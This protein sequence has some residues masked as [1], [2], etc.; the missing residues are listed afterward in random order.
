MSSPDLRIFFRTKSLQFPLHV[1]PDLRPWPIGWNQD[2]RRSFH[3]LILPRDA[4]GADEGN[5]KILTLE[6]KGR[7]SGSEK[8]DNQ[9]SSWDRRPDL[10]D[11]EKAE[12]RG[13]GQ[14]RQEWANYLT[15]QKVSGR[16]GRT[17]EPQHLRWQ[18]QENNAQIR[19]ECWCCSS[20]SQ[21]ELVFHQINQ[22]TPV[23]E[24]SHTSVG[25]SQAAHL[26]ALKWH[27]VNSQ[28]DAKLD[29]NSWFTQCLLGIHS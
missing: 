1:Q 29:E 2:L 10:W 24:A 15:Q 17:S 20:L 13:A 4:E 18:W 28:A 25:C 3:C 19:Q 7:I 6:E 27:H 5:I 21:K 8:M 14:R 11:C 26:S 16:V 22:L 23:D 9:P 12:C